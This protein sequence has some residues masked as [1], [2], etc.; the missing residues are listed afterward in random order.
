MVKLPV[1]D[2]PRVRKFL[3]TRHDKKVH[4]GTSTIL[5]EKSQ[6][7]CSIGVSLLYGMARLGQLTG[8]CTK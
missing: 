5:V 1:V 4:R 8:A 3:D 6:V 2:D 7:D